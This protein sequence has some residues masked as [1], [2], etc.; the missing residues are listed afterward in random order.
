MQTADPYLILKYGKFCSMPT[1]YFHDMVGKYC[2]IIYNKTSKFLQRKVEWDLYNLAF[3]ALLSGKGGDA[4][5]SALHIA[6]RC[7]KWMIKNQALTLQPF[8][9]KYKNEV[10]WFGCDILHYTS[11]WLRTFVIAHYKLITVPL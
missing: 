8:I 11:M 3:D 6:V 2:V 7:F 5:S 1:S 9:E 10:L 4:H